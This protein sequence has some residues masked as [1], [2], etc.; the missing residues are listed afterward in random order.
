M[1][2]F[3]SNR[4]GTYALYE[5]PSNG[6]RKEELIF[7]DPA[8]KFTSSWSPDGKYVLFD[9]L[10]PQPKG[11]TAIWVLPMSGDHK[12]FSLIATD[13]DDSYGVFSPDGKWV[14]YKSNESGKDEI[15]A[16]AFP[17]PAARFQI[18]TS[19]GDN[20]QWRA[21]GKELFYTDPENRIMAVDV[22]AHGETLEIGTPHSLFVPRLQNVN[23][24]Y[25]ATADGK[26]FL[27]NEQPPQSAS[28]LTVV[29]NWD[30]DLKK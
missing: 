30:A 28:H 12:A 11:R 21:D 13:F 18:S 5:K 29:F 24:P 9:R 3:D 10:D 15:Y 22:A 27:V 2:V 20:P 16:V 7:T 6:A 25:A 19:G 17:T 8:T 4:G 1:I 23:P 26:R 14:A